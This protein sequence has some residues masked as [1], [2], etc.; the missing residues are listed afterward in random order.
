MK[1]H[2]WKNNLEYCCAKKVVESIECQPSKQ[3]NLIN[4]FQKKLVNVK[5]TNGQESL[6]CLQGWKLNFQKSSKILRC[7]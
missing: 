4:M 2:P 1:S 6:C 7:Y 3:A 5:G